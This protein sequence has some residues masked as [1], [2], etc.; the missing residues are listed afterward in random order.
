MAMSQGKNAVEGDAASVRERLLDTAERLFSEHG[1]EG[2]SVRDLA[3]AAGCNIAS[4]NYYF[5]SKERLYEEVFRRHFIPM[6]DVRVAS[7][8]KVMTESNGR[9][10]L[11]VLLKAFADA[12]I[13][14][15][16][17]EARASR[18]MK[19]MVREM[20]DNHLPSDLFVKDV[21]I[22]TVSAMRT[23]LVKACPGLDESKVPLI[24]HSVIGQLV[25]A[26]HSERMLERAGDADVPKFPLATVID[27]IVKFSAAGIRAYA[28]EK[29]E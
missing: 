11:E 15:L 21:I 20:I 7:I 1:F 26:V 10:E 17:D 24:V 14:P 16:A 8:D 23:G 25:Q 13:E 5:G 29:S 6:T 4:V 9:P 18:F 2:T 12:F 27:H 22:P 19:L 28:G 3:S